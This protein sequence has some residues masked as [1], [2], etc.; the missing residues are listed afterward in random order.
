M[1]MTDPIADMLTRIR[2]GLHAKHKDVLIPASAIKVSI[3][4]ILKAEGYIKSYRV[5]E[6][7]L[8]KLIKVELKYDEFEVGVITEIKRLS[9]PGRRIYV[10]KDD[11]PKVMNG[12]GVSI[13]S[14]S[15]GIMTGENARKEGVGGELV[16]SL[17]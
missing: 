14:T 6:G 3:A 13:L 7:K 2:N 4:E 16:C 12:L 5:I 8:P 11:I 15:K 9:K 10:G 1:S 17:Y